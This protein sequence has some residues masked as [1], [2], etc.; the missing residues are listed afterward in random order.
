MSA[1]R[2]SAGAVIYLQPEEFD[3]PP[4]PFRTGEAGH[5]WIS[6][7]GEP[8]TDTRVRLSANTTH[9]LLGHGVVEALNQLPLEMGPLGSGGDVMIPQ[10]LLEDASEILVEADRKT[11]GAVFE[12]CAGPHPSE[13]GLECWVRV[14]NREYQRSLARLQFLVGTASRYGHAVRLRI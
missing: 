4:A 8:E 13:P 7:A 11:Y 1:N 3:A 14:Q 2:P 10:G 6:A 9:A 12:F 5:V